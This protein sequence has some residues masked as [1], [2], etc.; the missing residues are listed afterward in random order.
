M[1]YIYKITN[2]INDKVYIG[3]TKRS[4]E[5][6]WEEHKRYSL[7]ADSKTKFYQAIKTIGIEH[8][9][10]EKIEEI[11]GVEER[12]IR[13]IYWIKFYD[14]FHNGYNSTLGGGCIDWY[15]IS[16]LEKIDKVIEMRLDGASYDKIIETLHCSRGM[17]SK[18]LKEH[19]LSG[20]DCRSLKKTQSIIEMLQQGHLLINI[21]KELKC[22]FNVIKRI[23]DDHPELEEKY[24]E[25][26]HPLDKIIWDL[27]KNKLLKPQEISQQLKCSDETIY[28]ALDRMKRR[29]LQNKDLTFYEK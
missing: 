2:D 12:N 20:Q 4:I 15:N 8:F 26:Y 16:Y 27:R 11:F 1:G 22:D 7:Q 17:I 28:R 25:V 13:E 5:K 9:H 3:Q 10:I 29:L 18:I 23:L 6:R 21:Q 14:S 24:Y 19:N